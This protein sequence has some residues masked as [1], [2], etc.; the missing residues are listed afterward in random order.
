MSDASRNASERLLELLADRAAF[1]LTS[2]PI[3][4]T[5]WRPRSI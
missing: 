2:M 1:G 4:S 3:S 5:V